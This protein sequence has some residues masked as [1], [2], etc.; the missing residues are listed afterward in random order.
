LRTLLETL[1]RGLVNEPSRVRVHE[2]VELLQPIEHLQLERAIVLGQPKFVRA[3]RQ[4]SD[5]TILKTGPRFRR[6]IELCGRFKLRA[7]TRE[8][9]LT[10]AVSRPAG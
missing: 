6:R 9:G 4:A 10:R 5:K 1:A 3:Q 8:L 7:K 2:H